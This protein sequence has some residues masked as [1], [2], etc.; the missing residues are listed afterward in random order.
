V[1]QLLLGVNAFW[2]LKIGSFNE[3]RGTPLRKLFTGWEVGNEI[4]HGELWIAWQTQIIFSILT[5][6]KILKKIITKYHFIC[7]STLQKSN[8]C[9][10]LFGRQKVNTKHI[11]A[12][13]LWDCVL[14][15]SMYLTVFGHMFQLISQNK[16]ITRICRDSI[17]VVDWWLY[18]LEILNDLK[19]KQGCFES[20]GYFLYKLYSCNFFCYGRQKIW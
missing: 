9:T 13:T 1:Q 10:N 18:F 8:K 4:H 16:N 6:L 11:S 19:S 5:Y 20:P 17:K 3:Y 15:A 12:R 2:K 14:G 7:I